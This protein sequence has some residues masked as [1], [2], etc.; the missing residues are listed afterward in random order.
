[1]VGI[2][3]LGGEREQAAEFGKRTNV[4]TGKLALFN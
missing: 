1:M 4:Q 3:D 2:G